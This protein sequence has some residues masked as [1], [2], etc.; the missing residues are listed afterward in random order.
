MSLLKKEYLAHI[1]GRYQ[2]AGR[3]Q[4]KLQ[5]SFVR[6]ALTIASL[7]CAC[8][9][10]PCAVGGAGQV[11]SSNTTGLVYCLPSNASGFWPINPAENCS[12]PLLPAVAAASCRDQAGGAKGFV[13]HAAPPPGPVAQTFPFP[14]SPPRPVHHQTRQTAAPSR[15]TPRRPARHQTPGPHRGGHRG[16][17]WR[18]CGRGFHLQPDFHG[19]LHRLDG[20][21]AT[22]NKSAQG[23]LA[24]LKD[25]ESQLP[26]KMKS[27]HADNGS[28]VL[29]RP[30]WDYLRGPG[31]RSSSPAAALIARTTTPTWSKRTGRMFGSCSATSV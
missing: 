26:F 20:D 9:T 10:G 8:S 17:L 15:S 28:G 29:N 16:P 7:P 18:L 5:V 25:I 21:R 1:H 13:G 4:S 3:T 2:R 30:L 24:Q 6:S 31:A 12:K 23:I 19:C 11:P 22:W 27:F 14:V